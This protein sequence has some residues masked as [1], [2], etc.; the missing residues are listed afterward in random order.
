MQKTVMA[1]WVVW[2]ASVSGAATNNVRIIDGDTVD[3]NG[4]RYRLEGIDA[5]EISQQCRAYSGT[6][7][8][9]KAARN[10]LEDMTTGKQVECVGDQ[11]D[12]YGRVLDIVLL[13]VAI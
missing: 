9:G 13:T 4:V 6:W 8:C 7:E 2:I 1:I 3:V 11:T 5:P 10:A 12:Y